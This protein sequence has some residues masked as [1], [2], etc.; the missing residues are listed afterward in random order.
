MTWFASSWTVGISWLSLVLCLGVITSLAIW[1]RGLS[2]ARGWAVLAFVIACP[3]A[4]FSLASALGYPMPYVKGVTLPPGKHKVLGGKIVEGVA[5]YALLDMEDGPPRLFSFPYTTDG[6][7]S[8]QQA[9]DEA[10]EG[11]EM[12]VEIPGGDGE[13]GPPQPEF[14]ANFPEPMPDKE[15]G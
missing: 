5:L 11:A 8:M 2:K 10:V 3:L 9:M 6:A 4:A 15:A 7:N 1:A 12:T 14:D 13:E